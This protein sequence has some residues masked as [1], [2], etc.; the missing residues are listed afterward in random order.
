MAKDPAELTTGSESRRSF[1]AM[2]GLGAAALA[3]LSTPFNRLGKGDSGPSTAM[4]D[5]FPGEDS[6]FHPAQDPRLDP[7]RK[8]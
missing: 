6:I 2:L 1:L 4:S 3:L 8:S 5:A 7:R